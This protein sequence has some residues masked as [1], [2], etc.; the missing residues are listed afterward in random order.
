MKKLPK[1]PVIGIVGGRGIL[2]KIFR[3]AFEDAGFEVL[4]SGRKPDGKKILPTQKL[5][6]KSDIVIVSVFLDSTE[7][8]LSEIVPKMPFR[9]A[10]SPMSHPC[11]CSDQ[12]RQRTQ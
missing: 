9:Y 5:I 7:K 2:G 10:S 4:I 6:K 3:A 12:F 11:K 1:N 8:V